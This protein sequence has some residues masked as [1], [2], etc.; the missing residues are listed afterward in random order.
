VIQINTIF[1]LLNQRCV[2]LSPSK[3]SCARTLP[4]TIAFCSSSI[5]PQHTDFHQQVQTS[6]WLGSDIP[7]PGLTGLGRSSLKAFVLWVLNVCPTPLGKAIGLQF[8]SNTYSYDCEDQQCLP[9][10]LG[11][12]FL[13]KKNEIWICL[14]L[15]HTKPSQ[16]GGRKIQWPNTRRDGLIQILGLLLLIVSCLFIV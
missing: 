4:I 10:M 13:E 3:D 8:R 7:F 11:I 6:A 15:P 16:S 14:C 9:L 5:C 1:P 12:L 2:S